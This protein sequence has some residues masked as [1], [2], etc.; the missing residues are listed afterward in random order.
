MT[1]RLWIMRHGQAA[2]GRPDPERTLTER[3]HA[4][5]ARMAA[6]LARRD[7]PDLARLRL[8]TSPYVRA[9]QTA[10]PIAEALSV[11]LEPLPLITPDDPPEAVIDWLL[12]QDEDRPLMLVSH[13][14]LVASLT[15]LLVEGYPDRG[16]GFATA[17]LAELAAE[18]RA[19]GC[20]RLVR[21]VAPSDIA[22]QEGP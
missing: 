13:M 21:L 7:D 19:A 9:R 22:D 5:A 3:G 17:A 15:G 1:E 10:A 16:P 18:V 11:A 8:L 6:W 12:E 4:E 20:A 2:P 14:P